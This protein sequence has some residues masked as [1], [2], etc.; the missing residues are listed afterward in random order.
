MQRP[1]IF[2]FLF[3]LGFVALAAIGA[4]AR[5]GSAPPAAVGSKATIDNPSGPKI[6]VAVEGPA[7]EKT[8]LQVACVFE[9][10]PGDISQP[11]ALPA[12]V[13]GMLHLDRALQGLISE[14]RKSG[15][16]E[17]HALE[18]LLLTPRRK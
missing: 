8:P 1:T 9:Y 3:S 18:T 7:S 12:A 2:T 5:A 13:N 15:R 4:P 17:G 6:E 16:F 14:L 11:P 10:V